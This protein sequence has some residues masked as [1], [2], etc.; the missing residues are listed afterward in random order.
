MKQLDFE[1][2]IQNID[3][4]TEFIDTELEMYGWKGIIAN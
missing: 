2:I 4:V 1:A 3:S